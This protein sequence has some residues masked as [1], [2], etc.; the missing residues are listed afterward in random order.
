M[1]K[2]H[3]VETHMTHVLSISSNNQ[4]AGHENRNVEFKSR[5]SAIKPEHFVAFANGGGGSLYVGVAEG[6]DDDGCQ[7]GEIIGCDVC[8]LTK[9]RLINMAASCRP[10]ID[11]TVYVEKSGDDIYFLRVDIPEGKF[12]PYSTA[13]GLYKTRI[14]G[15]NMALEPEQLRDM[16]LQ[17]EEEAFQ[18]RLEAS[19]GELTFSVRRLQKDLSLFLKLMRFGK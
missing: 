17:R 11:V 7:Y 4:L 10:C 16:V 2:G 5:I 14:D 8:D 18:K 15:R 6:S 1:V 12:K 3:E 19:T 13:S 9:Q